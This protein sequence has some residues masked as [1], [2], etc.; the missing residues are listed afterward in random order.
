MFSV[1]LKILQLSSNNKL[2]SKI[3][4]TSYLTLTNRPKLF[5]STCVIKKG[6]F[7]FHRL[8][9]SV[10]IDKSIKHPSKHS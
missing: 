4:R 9:L 3:P 7:D 6:L 2:V 5:Q 1:S 8:K 10:L